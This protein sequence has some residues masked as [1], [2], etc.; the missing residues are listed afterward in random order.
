MTNEPTVAIKQNTKK[1][2]Q[3]KRGKVKSKKEKGAKN[4]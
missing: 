4:R 2:T 1:I 3:F